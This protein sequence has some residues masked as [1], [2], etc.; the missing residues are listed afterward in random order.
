MSPCKSRALLDRLCDE[1]GI[2]Q[3]CQRHPVDPVRVAVRLAAAELEREAC[4][5]GAARPG[6]R[7]QTRIGEDCGGL[8]QLPPPPQEARPQAWVG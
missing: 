7:Q 8:S 3:R 5:A 2:C 4:L 6:H 1:G